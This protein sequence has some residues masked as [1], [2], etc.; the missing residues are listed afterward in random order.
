[1]PSIKR[2][3][4]DPMGNCPLPEVDGERFVRVPSKG[5]SV[6]SSPGSNSAGGLA[7]KQEW[8]RAIDRYV[9]SV[10]EEHRKGS[11]AD[12]LHILSLAQNVEK[13]C[14]ID[15]C[16]NIDDVSF[17]PI[18]P[19]NESMEPK[20]T[21][22]KVS[23]KIRENWKPFALL[24][25]VV[26]VILFISAGVTSSNNKGK[27]KDGSK[28]VGTA[29]VTL[30]TSSPSA[31]PTTESPTIFPTT[32]VPT[33][34]PSS[35]PFEAPS[36]SP[37]TALTKAPT[38]YPNV[39]LL[40]PSA[41][42]TPSPSPK[43]TTTTPTTSPIRNPTQSPTS[44]PT[45]SPTHSPTSSPTSRPT[46]PEKYYEMK[47][48][49]MYVSGKSPFD[50]TDTAQS[51][52]FHWLYYE[53]SPS[54]NLYEFFEQYATAV[55][56]FSL[57]R[58]RMSSI[59]YSLAQDDFTT[60][61]EVCGWEGV[62]CAYNYTSEMAHVTEIRLPSKQLKGTIPTEIGFLPYLIRLDFAYNELAGT[63]PVDLYS[64]KRLR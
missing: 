31:Y 44:L 7:S 33:G 24:F 48:A 50:A 45:T 8:S 56:F 64:L 37:T 47:K 28:S 58:A 36:T 21:T 34:T 9:A 49:A 46:M 3:G 23:R 32:A 29:T 16:G 52:A 1:M 2:D 42:P 18:T 38:S 40:S 41:S 27:E 12:E 22:K 11:Q 43:P 19:Y 63:I 17:A 26:S 60:R 57:T 59:S 10:L 20:L 6:A 13:S 5:A 54:Q 35:K 4:H 53:G 61:R 39:T 30:P 15:P 14:H 62:R 25:L 51:L 55:V